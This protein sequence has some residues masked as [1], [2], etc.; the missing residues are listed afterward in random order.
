MDLMS[1]SRQQLCG[2][3]S[4]SGALKAKGPDPEGK[5]YCSVASWAGAALHAV[6]HLNTDSDRNCST[7]AV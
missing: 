3:V 5:R 1:L 2:T 4:E 7:H 6:P